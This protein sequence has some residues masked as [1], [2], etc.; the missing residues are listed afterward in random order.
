MQ[1]ATS[2]EQR[3]FNDWRMR[4]IRAT[5]ASGES[6]RDT[7]EWLELSESAYYRRRRG[8]MPFT[9]WELIRLSERFGLEMAP[10]PPGLQRFS[11]SAPLSPTQ[12]FDEHRYLESIEHVAERFR[13]REG[14]PVS[15]IRISSSDIPVFYL[16]REPEL[17]ALKRYL[18]TLAVDARDATPF[19][20]DKEIHEATQ[21]IRRTRCVNEHYSEAASEE[22]WGP[23]PLRSLVHQ[24]LLLVESGMLHR[25]DSE[26]VFVAAA[27]VVDKL[28]EQLTASTKRRSGS[29]RL[30]QNRLHSTNSTISLAN[31]RHR[32][33]YLTFDNPN[34]IASQGEGAVAYFNGHFELLRRRSRRVA[35][36]GASS[37][38]RF[39]AELRAALRR[40]AA[41]AGQ[42]FAELDDD[43]L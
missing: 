20:L 38:A 43:L 36:R 33:L 18:F 6:A 21:F 16:F 30:W 13:V 4:L 15:R 24:I 29:L 40:G 26:A 32:A 9:A 34:F 22:I 37:P 10:S 27:R 25:A 7:A 14:E 17:A 8:E 11:F 31:G 23:G 39:C 28:E 3:F 42:I 2:P 35:G 41:R 5:D 12:A 19:R 1:I